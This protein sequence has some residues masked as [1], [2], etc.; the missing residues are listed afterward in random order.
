MKSWGDD[1]EDGEGGTTAPVVEKK[2]G[3]GAKA[4]PKPVEVVDDDEIVLPEPKTVITGDI[5][6]IISFTKLASGK[7]EKKTRTFRLE[8]RSV[9][10]SQAVSERRT[11]AKFGSVSIG[12]DGK[13]LPPGPDSSSTN[14]VMDDVFL[15]LS[16]SNEVRDDGEE[17][18]PLKKLKG[19]SVVKC[20]HCGGDH[21]STKCPFKDNLPVQRPEGATAGTEAEGAPRPGGAPGAGAVGPNGGVSNTSVYVP[22]SQRAGRGGAGGGG[23]SM[24]DR[25][26]SNTVRVTNLSENTREDD[27]RDLFRSY[28]HITR[29]YLATNKET[30]LGR[31]FAFVSFQRRE[32]A[33]RAISEV[34]GHGYDHLILQL[35][36]AEDRKPGD[37][38]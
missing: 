18:D 16:S 3:G 24:N 27:L 4:A 28:G 20:R 9:R 23:S 15:T 30:G 22:P 14:V 26:D 38:K 2:S 8:K 1:D 36:W 31:G 7:I 10:L 33:A 35:D 29:C 6:K 13:L 5:K 37:K 12:P 25:D 17:E 21:W 19:A 11:W 34:N 32:D